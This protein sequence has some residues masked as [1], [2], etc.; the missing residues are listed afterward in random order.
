MTFITQ[1]RAVTAVGLSSVPA[2]LGTSMVIVVG[3]GTVVAVL[4]GALALAT[5]FT[6]AAARTGSPARAIVRYPG[7]RKRTAACPARAW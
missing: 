2:R 7:T 1:V 4:L 3:V 5:G 6:K